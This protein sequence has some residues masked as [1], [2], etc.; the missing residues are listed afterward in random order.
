VDNTVF[1]ALQPAS[2]NDARLAAP[3]DN[4]PIDSQAAVAEAPTA[5]GPSGQGAQTSSGAGTPTSASVA[6]ASQVP[7]TSAGALGLAQTQAAQS[8][9]APPALNPDQGTGLFSQA[10]TL[11]QPPAKPLSASAAPAAGPTAKGQAKTASPAAAATSAQTVQDPST[12]G[13]AAL[14]GP[15]AA[16]ADEKDGGSELDPGGQAGLAD[17]GADP[18]AAAQ[19][20]FQPDSALASAQMQSVSAAAAGPTV[21]PKVD[22]Q[23]VSQLSAQIVQTTSGG[24]SS[25]E[26]ILHPEG[27]GDVRVKVSVDRNGAVTADMS[28]SNP[29]AAAELGA[30]AGDL[31]DALAQAGFTV[32]D[33]GLNF[34]LG[35]QNQSGAGQNAWANDAG[36][37]AG[38]AFQTTADAAEDLLSSVSQAA[39]RLQRP[40]GGLDIRI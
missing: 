27:L 8:F 1:A 5:S 12:S 26:M 23:T 34:N 2:A 36:A 40:A 19:A 38:R 31:K 16:K 11:S 21:Q 25:F 3:A 17:Q 20:T 18:S 9:A 33:N 7:P 10:Q 13:V 32:A 15:L 22:A 37:N 35:G 4:T 39:I 30:R 29:Q 14:A 28:F 6:D 24:K